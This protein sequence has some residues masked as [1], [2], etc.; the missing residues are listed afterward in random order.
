M[1]YS[2]LMK[3]AFL[4]VIA[5]PLVP[6]TAQ[7]ETYL[8]VET[9][10]TWQSLN[11]QRIPGE[12]GDLFSISDF[13]DGPFLTYRVYLGHRFDEKHEVRAL[14][15]PLEIEAK[16]E[17]DESVRFIDSTFAPVSETTINYKFNSY[18]LSYIYH[19]ES[20]GDWRWAVGFTGKVRDAEVR[21]RQGG[22]DEKKA[23]VGFVPLAHLEGSWSFASDWTLLFDLDGLAAPQG[24]A[25]DLG[26]FVKRSFGANGLSAFLGYRTVEGGADNDKVYNFAWLHSAT[27]GLEYRN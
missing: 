1:N 3:Y 27:L 12:G 10:Q 16:G 25:F 13:D 14:Y 5:S 17:F 8:S 4:F 9:A 22:L 18:R 2:Q 20:Q 21:V 23:N 7:A 24:R 15:A 6:V 19:F 26:I 11:D